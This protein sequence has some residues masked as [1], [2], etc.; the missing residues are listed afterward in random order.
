MPE[1]TS[2]AHSNAYG[3]YFPSLVLLL[4]AAVSSCCFDTDFESTRVAPRSST[5]PGLLS[6]W[7][8]GV[9]SSPHAV[10][11]LRYHERFLLRKICKLSFGTAVSYPGCVFGL[12][13]TLQGQ[14]V[15]H[16]VLIWWA[17]SQAAAPND[18]CGRAKKRKTPLLGDSCGIPF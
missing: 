2:K 15:M 5:N 13:E 1:T 14:R 16:T 11:G 9:R 4:R 8:R 3:V 17:A 10:P 7:L 6:A 18:D 12:Y